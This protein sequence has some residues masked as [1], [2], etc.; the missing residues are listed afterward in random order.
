MFNFGS[1]ETEIHKTAQS[2]ATDMAL[3]EDTL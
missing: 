3:S 2:K 1:P